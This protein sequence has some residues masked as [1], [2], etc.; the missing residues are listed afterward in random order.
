MKLLN[1]RRLRIAWSKGWSVRVFIR[2]GEAASAR[3]IAREAARWALRAIEG[4]P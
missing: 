2:R 4:R 1:L 3:N